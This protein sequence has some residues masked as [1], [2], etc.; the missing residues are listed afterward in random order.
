DFEKSSNT[1]LIFFESSSTSSI[2]YSTSSSHHS[3]FASRVFFS[4][5][6]KL[7]RRFRFRICAHCDALS[8]LTM[9]AQQQQGQDEPLIIDDNGELVAA[10]A[11]QQQPMAAQAQLA[12]QMQQAAG[13]MAHQAFVG[14]GE[15]GMQAN[16]A[17]LATI[18]A[19]Q[20][21]AI[22]LSLA[23]ETERRAQDAQRKKELA[24]DQARREEETIRT[25]AE[26]ATLSI[27]D[28]QA[29]EGVRWAMTIAS[30]ADPKERAVMS[31]AFVEM[32]I[33]QEEMADGDD[34]EDVNSIL[35]AAVRK[36]KSLSPEQQEEVVRK[37]KVKKR[38]TAPAARSCSKCG[39]DGHASADCYAQARAVK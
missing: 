32:L 4:L 22:E 34:L 20:Q 9:A 16:A 18:L 27:K 13:G 35:S 2:H 12:G 15:A 30:L 7:H 3:R 36:L 5:I 8:P 28:P 14:A 11:E 21:K 10:A 19:L 37:L 6:N 25:Q 33:R 38:K 24:A 39:R 29:K 1:L 26:T 23:Q 17:Q 31:K